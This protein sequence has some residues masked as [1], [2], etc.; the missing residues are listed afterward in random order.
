MSMTLNETPPDSAVTSAKNPPR[1]TFWR[2]CAARWRLFASKIPKPIK[3]VIVTTVGA[4]LIIGG[5]LLSLPMV[6]GPGT[7]LILAGVAVLASEFTWARNLLAK[8]KACW[9]WFKPKYVDPW[10]ARYRSWRGSNKS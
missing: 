10:I 3:I 7:A 5:V 6:P 8:I 9:N 2:G 1:N 4:I